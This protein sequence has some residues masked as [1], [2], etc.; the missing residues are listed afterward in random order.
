[1]IPLSNII[2]IRCMNGIFLSFSSIMSTKHHFSSWYECAHF[3][4]SLSFVAVSTWFIIHFCSLVGVFQF[5]P[6]QLCFISKNILCISMIVT[7][8]WCV[9]LYIVGSC[10]EFPR[11]AFCTLLANRKQSLVIFIHRTLLSLMISV[12]TRATLA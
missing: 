11:R 8:Y 6:E 3:L 4:V 9:S 1:M 7:P 10:I 5:P 2:F 12:S